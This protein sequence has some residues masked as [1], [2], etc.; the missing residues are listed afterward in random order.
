MKILV[1]VGGECFEAAYIDV[2][3][4]D[5]RDGVLYYFRLRDLIKD[6]GLR[7]VSLF[8]SGTDRV[9][10]K[11][12]EDRVE[13]VRLN[14]LRRAFDSGAFSFETPVVHDRFHELLLRATDF[15]PQKL[16]S[17]EVIRRFF[18]IGGY[19]LG[20]KYLS[21]EPNAYIDFDC[22]EDLDYLGA[23]TQIL[24]RNLRLLSEQGY[25]KATIVSFPVSL[26]VR[27]TAKLIEEIEGSDGSSK[28]PS[29]MRGNVTQNI[30]LHG[31]N[32][33]INVNSTDNSVN[34]TS[35]SGDQ[36]LFTQLRETARSIDNES[37][38]AEILSKLD[39]LQEMLGSSG[40]LQEYQGFIA[41]VANYMTIFGP[42]IPALTRMISGS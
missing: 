18:K 20:F 16:A 30:H 31:H 25:F 28:T 34:I 15:Q 17:D 2:G 19:W 41:T 6:R 21:H 26:K 35:V 33:R 22:A 9:F 29:T 1:T 4:A 5:G 3:H 13:T 10:V 37:E 12:Y 23:T 32:P 40:F 11:D 8:R 24:A 42:F 27:P 36:Q 39:R 7:N 14:V 38:R